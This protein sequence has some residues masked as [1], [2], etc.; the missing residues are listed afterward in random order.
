LRLYIRQSQDKAKI[1]DAGT[2]LIEEN[3]LLEPKVVVGCGME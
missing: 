1:D 3:V 2:F